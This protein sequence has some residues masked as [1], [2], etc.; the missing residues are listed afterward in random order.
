MQSNPYDILLEKG[1]QRKVWFKF[2]LPTLFS[3]TFSNLHPI[4]NIA[5]Y[6]YKAGQVLEAIDP[7]TFESE[8]QD[9][10]NDQL[11]SFSLIEIVP[12][13]FCQNEDFDEL[14]DALKEK[15]NG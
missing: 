3:D 11:F 8:F 2:E 1:L 12:G 15:K 7:E 10:L 4:V 13:L 5:G 14:N 9:W 6:S